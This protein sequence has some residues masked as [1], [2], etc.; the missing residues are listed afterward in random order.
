MVSA[1]HP[2]LAMEGAFGAMKLHGEELNR[3]AGDPT[4]GTL[5]SWVPGRLA[6]AVDAHGG[7]GAPGTPQL[8]RGPGA[9]D[10]GLTVEV[11]QSAVEPNS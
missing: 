2:A 5:T 9:E 11:A 10:P 6:V 8:R 7:V 4:G 1:R 3:A